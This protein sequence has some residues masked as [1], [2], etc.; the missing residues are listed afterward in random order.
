MKR[1]KNMVNNPSTESREL[2]LYTVNNAKIYPSISATIKNLKKKY[3]K[4][5]YNT[6][7]A[8]D[9]WY[10]IA[11]MGSSA[12]NKDFGYNFTVTERFSA[13]VELEN[14]FKEDIEA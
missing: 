14:Y 9:A 2:F 11:T 1:T 5:I 7:K 6:E 4:G 10:Y 8:I 13:S 12:Y 3:E